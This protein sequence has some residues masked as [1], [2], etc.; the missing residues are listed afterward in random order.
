VVKFSIIGSTLTEK[1]CSVAFL[2][3]R[4]RFSQWLFALKVIE[5]AK[6]KQASSAPQGKEAKRE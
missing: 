2:E 4:N 6:E 1:L 5:M 3:T